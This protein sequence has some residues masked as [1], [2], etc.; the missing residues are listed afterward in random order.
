MLEHHRGGKGVLD[1]TFADLI[2]QRKD[3]LDDYVALSFKEMR[4]LSFEEMK[5]EMDDS[6]TPFTSRQFFCPTAIDAESKLPRLQ[7]RMNIFC[8]FME[9]AGKD[10]RL[11]VMSGCARTSSRFAAAF[12]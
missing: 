1:E 10:T 7:A 6:R 5:D 4:A 3:L 9:R 2:F 11:S 12:S 8:G